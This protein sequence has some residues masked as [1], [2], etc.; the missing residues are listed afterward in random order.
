MAFAF[1]GASEFFGRDMAYAH[2]ELITKQ[3]LN[4]KSVCCGLG[5]VTL[6]LL[7]V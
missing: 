1:G 7:A 4:L 2:Y 6:V 3:G 5:V